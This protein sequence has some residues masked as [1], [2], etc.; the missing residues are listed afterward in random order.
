MCVYSHLDNRIREK[1]VSGD[2]GYCQKSRKCL[3]PSG[4]SRHAHTWLKT[5]AMFPACYPQT[6]GPGSTLFRVPFGQK[7]WVEELQAWQLG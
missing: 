3:L 5:P 1:G 2:L 7:L 4:P 6:R